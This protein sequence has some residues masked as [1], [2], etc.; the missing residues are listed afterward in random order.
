[1]VEGEEREGEGG[2]E[3]FE[4]GCVDKLRVAVARE[5]KSQRLLGGDCLQCCL[6]KVAA[7]L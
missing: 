3:S 4:L 2:D 1:M 7:P 5:Y 6:C